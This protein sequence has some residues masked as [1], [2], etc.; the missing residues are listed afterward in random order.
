M[1]WQNIIEVVN[2]L[3]A[4]DDEP[5]PVYNSRVSRV[6]SRVKTYLSVRETRVDSVGYNCV[7]RKFAGVMGI[8]E[9]Y[10]K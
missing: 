6:V 2:I 5:P 10:K 9:F 4:E 7:Y 3:T 1:I 8:V